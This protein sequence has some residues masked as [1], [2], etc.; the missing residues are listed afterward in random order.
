MLD[1][2]DIIRG[3]ID[4]LVVNHKIWVSTIEAKGSLMSLSVGLPHTLAYVASDEN[5]TSNR[6]G[7]VINGTE[8]FFVKLSCEARACALSKTYSLNNPGNDLYDVVSVLKSLG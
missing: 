8:L 2:E 6:F 1:S 7:L 5:Q 3:R 4:I